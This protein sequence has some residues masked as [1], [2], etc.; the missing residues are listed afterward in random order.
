MNNSTYSAT[1]FDSGL[2]AQNYDALAEA[3]LD[4]YQPHRVLDVGC[5]PGGLSR[6]LARRGVAVTAVDGFADPA[7]AT[8]NIRFFRCDLNSA[9]QVAQLAQTVGSDFDAVVCLEVA[10]HL[11]TASSDQLVRFLCGRAPVV[12]FSAAVP[13]QGGA[14]HINCQTRGAWHDRFAATGYVLSHR[15]RPRLQSASAVP[16]WY[17]YNVLDY[18]RNRSEAPVVRALLES[19]SDL[20]SAYYA[21]RQEIV[22]LQTLQNQPVIR[23]WLGLRRALKRAIGRR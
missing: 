9:A 14:G 7:F 5:G 1:Y 6:A 17:R 11:D 3:I 21:A 16:D 23:A 20:A 2:F 10:E 19:E 22:R 12:I 15:V 13:G 8:D 18:V 4:A